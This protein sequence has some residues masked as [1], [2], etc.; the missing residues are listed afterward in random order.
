MAIYC[1]PLTFPYIP[2]L[3]IPL[4]TIFMIIFLVSPDL[5]EDGS[6]DPM[7]VDYMKQFGYVLSVN[8]NWWF[9]N[10]ENILPYD[11]TLHWEHFLY[12]QIFFIF[13]YFFNNIYIWG[14][15]LPVS[16]LYFTGYAFICEGC[17]F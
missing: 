3:G 8:Y 14:S 12:L 5:F 15:I 11:D 6:I 2:P 9:F 13:M 16:I 10:Y 1:Y 17:M 4:P 7:V